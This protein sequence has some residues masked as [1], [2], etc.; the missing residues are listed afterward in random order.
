KLLMS[1]I[2][3]FPSECGTNPT[4]DDREDVL[5]LGSTMMKLISNLACNAYSIGKLEKTTDLASS[6][7]GYSIGSGV[8]P[9]HSLQNHSCNPAT[10]HCTVGNYMVTYASRFIPAG[11]EVTVSYGFHYALDE[12]SERK[13]ELKEQFYFDCIC[14]ACVGEWPTFGNLSVNPSFCID[15]KE[16]HLDENREENEDIKK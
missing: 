5:F 7:T 3:Y 11:S 16:S 12:I 1:N 15:N 9:A 8:F 10:A 14:D 6:G 13:S 2:H 4:D